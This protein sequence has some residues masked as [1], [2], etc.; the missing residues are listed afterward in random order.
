MP[1][2]YSDSVLERSWQPFAI[3]HKNYRYHI[4][5]RPPPPYPHAFI[6]SLVVR[7]SFQF[8]RVMHACS[9]PCIHPSSRLRHT[10]D[11]GS[12]RI[13]NTKSKVEIDMSLFSLSPPRPLPYPSVLA[14]PASP[15]W[16]GPL[17]RGAVRSPR[18]LRHPMFTRLENVNVREICITSPSLG[19]CVPEA[20][21]S[22]SLRFT[23]FQK[24]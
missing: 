9:H 18:T 10:P 16:R 24:S 6:L 12:T 17:W 21:Q 13:S 15:A 14:H 5:P 11:D 4:V 20:Q 22:K 2:L 23:S 8:P 7:Y 19:Y 3:C 1:Y